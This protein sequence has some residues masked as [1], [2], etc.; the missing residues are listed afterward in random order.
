MR[1]ARPWH[2]PRQ[3]GQ[4]FSLIAFLVVPSVTDFFWHLLLLCL[5]QYPW[6][7][8]FKC[9]LAVTNEEKTSAIYLGLLQVPRCFNVVQCVPAALSLCWYRRFHMSWD[10]HIK[11]YNSGAGRNA[12]YYLMP[13]VCKARLA[14]KRV[15]SL[16]KLNRV[17]V[18]DPKSQLVSIKFP[19][20]FCC[21]YFT[22]GLP[23]NH[24]SQGVKLW[25]GRTLVLRKFSHECW[26]L[27]LDFHSVALATR[28]YSVLQEFRLLWVSGYCERSTDVSRGL[29]GMSMTSNHEKLRK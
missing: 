28:M 9:C 27:I 14:M 2:G 18:S 12:A 8:Q 17:A 10:R 25:T 26:T 21:S 16:A 29:A 24:R 11:S 15:T 3:F 4:N 20:L 6:F 19:F 23:E 22:L 7:C 1:V 13:L 5:F